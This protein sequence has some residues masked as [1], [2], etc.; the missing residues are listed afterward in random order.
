VGATPLGPA[1]SLTKIVPCLTLSI[2]MRLQVPPSLRAGGEAILGQARGSGLLRCARNVGRGWHEG[3]RGATLPGCGFVETSPDADLGPNGPLFRRT[4]W[5]QK[6]LMPGLPPMRSSM[7]PP[8]ASRTRCS[9]NWSLRRVRR[10]R[11]T[12]ERDH[13]LSFSPSLRVAESPVSRLSPSFSCSAGD[14]PVEAK[15]A[16][17]RASR[18][19]SFRSAHRWPGAS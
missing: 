2:V 11:M 13:V 8:R 17:M 9:A 4:R 18:H 6:L 15:P 7:S 1:L 16:F 3:R 5:R 10:L 12:R 19:F 14:E